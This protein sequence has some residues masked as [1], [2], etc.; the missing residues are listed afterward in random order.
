MSSSLLSP[1]F[2]CQVTCLI[3]EARNWRAGV[4]LEW[5]VDC[6][7]N[8][9]AVPDIDEISNSRSLIKYIFKILVHFNF[10]CAYNIYCHF[11]QTNCSLF[12]PFPLSFQ[13]ISISTTTL[14]PATSTEY[15][16]C[17]CLFWFPESSEPNLLFSYTNYIGFYCMWST[18]LFLTP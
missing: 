11:F 17:E 7:R 2:H 9:V 5:W 8:N 6:R 10:M 4:G 3:S 1:Y 12:K 14:L 15:M 16:Y 18:F 13:I